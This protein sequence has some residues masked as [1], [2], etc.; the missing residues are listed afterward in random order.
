MAARRPS[1]DERIRTAARGQLGYPRLRPGQLEGVRSILEGRDTLCVM[2][3]GSGKTAIYE[4]AGL[5]LD[6]PTVVVS[7]LIALQR[8]QVRELGDGA[9]AVF[10]SAESQH[11]RDQALA[12]VA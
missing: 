12:G 6:G 10:N 11:A 3:T 1:V 9:A 8:D 5:L 4:L 7:P 2:S